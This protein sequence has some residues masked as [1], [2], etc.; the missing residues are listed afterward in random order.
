MKRLIALLAAL[1]I[2]T[3]VHATTLIEGLNPSCNIMPVEDGVG[4]CSGGCHNLDWTNGGYST[5]NSENAVFMS[6]KFYGNESEGY[7][8]IGRQY[9]LDGTVEPGGVYRVWIKARETGQGDSW[10]NSGTFRLN[11]LLVN[12]VGKE[13]SVTIYGT[14]GTTALWYASGSVTMLS[15]NF[16]GTY[17]HNSLG[18]GS[19]VFACEC[20]TKTLEIDEIIVEPVSGN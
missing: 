14:L 2:A 3:T 4:G 18:I 7:D 1:T 12:N 17:T 6:A 10:T 11:I 19:N 15:S 13:H 20:A 9:C 16:T 5:V 8:F